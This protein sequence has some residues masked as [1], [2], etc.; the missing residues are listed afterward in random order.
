[1]KEIISRV[2]GRDR[3]PLKPKPKI[4]QKQTNLEDFNITD[5]NNTIGKNVMEYLDVDNISLERG[6]V[7]DEKR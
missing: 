1:M 2:L 6:G 5:L 3:E 4:E 7:H